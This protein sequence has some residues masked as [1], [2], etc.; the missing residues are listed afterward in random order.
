MMLIVLLSNLNKDQFNIS[1]LFS[2]Y[3]LQLIFYE[4]KIE[5]I[6]KKSYCDN[7]LS[8]P[9]I[10]PRPTYIKIGQNLSGTL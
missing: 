3:F 1:T 4:L 8:V 6:K 7:L 10:K 2:S 9:Y 5:L